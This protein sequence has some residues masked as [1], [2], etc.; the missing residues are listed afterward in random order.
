[1]FVLH[2]HFASRVIRRWSSVTPYRLRLRRANTR[3]C[4]YG[5]YRLSSTLHTRRSKPPSYAHS[6]KVSSLG[7]TPYLLTRKHHRRLPLRASDVEVF[8]KPELHLALPSPAPPVCPPILPR[9]DF[10]PIWNLCTPLQLRLRHRILD[11]IYSQLW[12]VM[13]GFYDV[14]PAHLISVFDYQVR[15]PWGESRRELLVLSS[16][17]GCCVLRPRVLLSNLLW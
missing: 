7:E 17:R 13:R 4:V 2:G 11:G 3:I 8:R 6:T 10:E 15:W 9:S 1:M 5:E 12:H 16:R 14:I